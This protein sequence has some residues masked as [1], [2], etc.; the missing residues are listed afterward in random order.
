MSIP[1]IFR[2]EAMTTVHWIDL[3]GPFMRL[4]SS[5]SLTGYFVQ[6]EI[7]FRYLF[8]P[9]KLIVTWAFTSNKDMNVCVSTFPEVSRK[10]QQ[11][12]GSVV[13]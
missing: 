10:F 13:L 6:T 1:I 8:F 4:R 7:E 11:V 5:P 12:I 9:L 3:K 2:V